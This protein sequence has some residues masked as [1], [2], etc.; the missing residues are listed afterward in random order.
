MSSPLQFQRIW[1]S[2]HVQ[3]VGFRYSTRRVAEGY[4][5][6]GSVQ[7]LDDGRVLIEVEGI[8]DEIKA[9][10]ED[11][12]YRMRSYIRGQSTQEEIREA[13]KFKDFRII[14]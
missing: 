2:G 7:N 1:Y 14:L 8:K 3:G 12:E 9:F 13:R 6:T 10:R 11:L 5:V 4:D